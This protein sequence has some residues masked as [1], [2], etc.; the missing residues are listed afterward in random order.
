MVIKRIIRI[1]WEAQDLLDQVGTGLLDQAGSAGTSGSAGSSGINGTS[2]SS[3]SAGS[4][5]INDLSGSS[6]SA[7][8]EWSKW[9]I[10]GQ[11]VHQGQVVLVVEVEPPGSSGSAGTSGQVEVGK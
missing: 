2:G 6:G 4:S 11:V 8:L 7:R 9:I 1:K 5:G 3:G 10:R